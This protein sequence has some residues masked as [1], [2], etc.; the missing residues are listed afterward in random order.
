M[1]FWDK[2]FDP[3]AL[4]KRHPTN[5]TCSDSMSLSNA[6]S[7]SCTSSDDDPEVYENGN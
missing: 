4:T 6:H 2:A 1:T 3:T 5:Q 7:L